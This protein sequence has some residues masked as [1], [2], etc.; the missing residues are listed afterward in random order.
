MMITPL[1]WEYI[2]A[3]GL[4]EKNFLPNGIGWGNESNKYMEA[5]RLLG[6]EFDRAR[7]K[8]GNIGNGK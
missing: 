5:M 2:R 4:Y 1:S 3:F 7:Q 6:M 8:Q